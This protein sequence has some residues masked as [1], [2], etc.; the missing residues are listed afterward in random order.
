[1]LTL[2]LFHQRYQ[3][4]C[5]CCHTAL[6]TNNTAS[7]TVNFMQISCKSPQPAVWLQCSGQ[8]HFMTNSALVVS[9]MFGY[10]PRCMYCLITALAINSTA[11]CS[12]KFHASH[13]SQMCGSSAVTNCLSPAH[14]G[15][16]CCDDACLYRHIAVKGMHCC[17]GCVAFLG[18][19]HLPQG[20]RSP[21]L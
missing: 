1:M 7:A 18:L 13:L 8:L 2:P 11:L 12:C 6:E 15:N 9:A 3:S 4:R 21:Q 16:V 17:P 20:M 14:G 19:R 5:M 10:Q